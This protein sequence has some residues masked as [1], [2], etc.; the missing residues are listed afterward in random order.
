M[1]FEVVAKK[2][3]KKYDIK[4][5]NLVYMMEETNVFFHVFTETKEYVLKI[6]QEES[7]NYNDNLA[8]HYFIGVINEKTDI[9]T[10]QVVE[11]IEGITVT[12][13][14]Y[15]NKRGYKRC[16][17]YSFLSGEGIYQLE[18]M[19]YFEKIG[20]EIAKM[21]LATSGLDFP[22]YVNPKK[23]KKIFYYEDEI[24]VYKK[25]KYSKYIT[26]EMIEILDELIPYIDRKLKF[27]YEKGEPQLI[28]A[29]MNPWNIKSKGERF[30][31]YDFEE[32]MLAYPIHDIAVFMYYY[33]YSDTFNFYDIKEAF[34]KGYETI[35]P[36]PSNLNLK[37]LELIMMARRINFFNYVLTINPNPK[38][39]LEM[40]FP[41]IKEYYLSY[42]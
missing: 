16:A 7:S 31:I 29:D 37:N 2:A 8:E 32:A 34:L 25:K 28:H 24:A 19:D 14:P 11:N 36:R 40:S 5:T 10:P 15:S 3:L 13:I 33:K 12:K 22:D 4:V 30:I 20:K 35:L 18:D 9:L 6:F 26:E 42:R 41:R 1:K 17:L 39:Y 27:F 23:W 21:H 38:E